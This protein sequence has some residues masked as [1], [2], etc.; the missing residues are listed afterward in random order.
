[1][2]NY[3]EG[4]FLTNREEVYKMLYDGGFTH[5][6]S[7]HSHRAGYYVM[8]H[9]DY[10]RKEVLVN[11]YTVDEA[12]YSPTEKLKGGKARLIV[13]AS[14]GPIAGQNSYADHSHIGLK[15]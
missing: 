15:T 13:G 7:G 3:E 14:G 8:V 10:S 5:V 1:M 11:G 9:N 12:G 4:T 2:S 6:F